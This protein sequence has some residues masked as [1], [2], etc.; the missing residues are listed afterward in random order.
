VGIRLLGALVL[1]FSLAPQALRATGT[2]PAVYLFWSA[3]SSYST[4]ARAFLHRLQ[5]AQP[6]LRLREFEVDASLA[7]AALLGQVYA[8]VGLSGVTAV[9]LIVIGHHLIVGYIDE[10]H[11]GRHIVETIAEC[12]KAGCRDPM[13]ALIDGT[14]TFDGVSLHNLPAP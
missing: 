14:G 6:D 13:R 11:T 5:A 2:G 3:G 12:R 1:A 4:S 10:E 9:P 8:R 7:N